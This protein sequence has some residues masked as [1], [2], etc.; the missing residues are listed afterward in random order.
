M[1]IR[2]IITAE[3]K[4]LT[5]TPDK[6]SESFFK[7][8]WPEDMPRIKRRVAILPIK[9]VKLTPGNLEKPGK[10]ADYCPDSRLPLK[11][12]GYTAPPEGF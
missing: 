8:D 11:R 3:Q 4:A 7:I 5:I 6:R 10:D 9:A 1:D 2:N 12:P